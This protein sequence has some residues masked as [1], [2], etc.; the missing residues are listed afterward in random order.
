MNRYLI[1]YVY[2]MEQLIKNLKF[3]LW[4]SIISF[5]IQ[6]ELLS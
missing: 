5:Y 1:V 6:V 3:D 4:R 2:H